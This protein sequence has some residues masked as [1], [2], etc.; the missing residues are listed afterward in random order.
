MPK[1]RNGIDLQP[2]DIVRHAEAASIVRWPESPKDWPI[3]KDGTVPLCCPFPGTTKVT[4][5]VSSVCVEVQPHVAR[6]P[7]FLAA[8]L[9]KISD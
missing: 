4:E 2:G 5:V 6:I 7:V 3:R 9:E 1:D 8:S